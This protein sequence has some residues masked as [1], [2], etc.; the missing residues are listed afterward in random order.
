MNHANG[1]IKD[2]GLMPLDELLKR[3]P[4]TILRLQNERLVTD[5]SADG[6]SEW[7]IHL[8]RFLSSKGRSSHHLL[9]VQTSLPDHCDSSHRQEKA[10]G[11]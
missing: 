9:W 1:N 7:V 6:F 5:G 11:R 8:H 3:V 4:I 10:I 2:P